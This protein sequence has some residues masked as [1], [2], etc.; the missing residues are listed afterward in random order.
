MSDAPSWFPLLTASLGVFSGGAAGALI[1][2]YIAHRRN[3][4]QP[5]EYR[6][7]VSH[8]FDGV[9]PSSAVTAAITL[10][11]GGAST[12]FNNLHLVN[13]EIENSGNMDL[14][15]FAF[16]ATAQLGYDFVHIEAPRPDAAHS[17]TIVAPPSPASKLHDTQITLAPLNRGNRYSITFYLVAD[18]APP[19]ESLISFSTAHPVNLVRTA[20]PRATVAAFEKSLI[21]KM[22]D[23]FAPSYMRLMRSYLE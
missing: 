14:A 22:V 13:A 18:Q 7:S 8:I 1:T 10:T 12:S 11:S 4:V 2:A 3:R 17:A 16:H 21:G 20:D 23:I 19:A 15:E 6:E 5:I 9:L